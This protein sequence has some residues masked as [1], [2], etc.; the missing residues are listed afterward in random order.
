MLT[1][2]NT[3]KPLAQAVC[4]HCGDCGLCHCSELF[5]PICIDCVN[6][7]FADRVSGGMRLN[8]GDRLGGKYH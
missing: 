8:D 4:E 6:V 5:P 2:D 3:P 1:V 7:I